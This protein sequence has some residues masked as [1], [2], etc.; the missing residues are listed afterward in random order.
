MGTFATTT[1][2]PN[3][4]PFFYKGNTTSSDTAGVAMFS[5]QVDRAEAEVMSYLSARYTMPFTTVPPLVR[6]ITEDIACYYL[7]RAAYTHDGEMQNRFLD[8]FK[9]AFTTLEQLRDGKS[10]LALTDGSLVSVRTTDKYKCSS[11]D[12]SQIFNHDGE[13]NWNVGEQQIDDIIADRDLE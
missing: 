3:L 4:L 5:A 12:Y 13:R 1:A 6:A 8:D 11:E 2:L 7:V 9:D 10:S